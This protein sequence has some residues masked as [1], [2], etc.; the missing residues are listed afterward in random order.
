MN[1]NAKTDNGIRLNKYL[2]EAGI[3]S[4][5]EADRL[6][7]DGKVTVDGRTAS[8]G[9]KVFTSQEITV[10]GKRVE[11]KERPVLSLPP[12]FRSQAERHCLYHLGQGQGGKYRG[13]FQVS[14]PHLSGRPS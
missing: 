6:I 8:M 11:G 5:R 3:C 13:I 2:S 12:F 7:E 1:D 10:N 14:G 9:M 4:R